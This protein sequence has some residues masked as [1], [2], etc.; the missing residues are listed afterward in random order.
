MPKTQP[1][2]GGRKALAMRATGWSK[3]SGPCKV[4]CLHCGLGRPHRVFPAPM[5]A[6]LLK[7]RNA[8]HGPGEPGSKPS[9]ARS[10][11]EEAV[12]KNLHLEMIG[13]AV[14]QTA[15]PI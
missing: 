15:K 13:S 14:G 9:R 2:D 5:R 8:L 12:D 6:T 11:M 10:V 3:K 1:S 4:G 7:G